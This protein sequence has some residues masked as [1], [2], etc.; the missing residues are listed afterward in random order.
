MTPRMEYSPRG[1]R[2]RWLVSVA[3]WAC[4]FVPRETLAARHA[5][6]E[7]QPAAP[8]LPDGLIPP[9]LEGSIA[10]EYP[11]ELATL[12]SPPEGEIGLRVVIGVR[13]SPVEVTV[14][15]GLHP[16]LDTLATEVVRAATFIPGTYQGTPVEVAI[17]INIPVYAPATPPSEPASDASDSPASPS[18]D[19]RVDESPTNADPQ[20]VERRSRADIEPI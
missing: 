4:V 2:T 13:G 17:E 14:T 5:S 15:R 18:R 7:R 16:R 10:L 11:A 20:P 12:D 8:T 3:L 19:A 9:A 6:E 1:R